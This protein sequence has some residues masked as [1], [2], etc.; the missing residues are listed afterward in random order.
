MIKTIN[1]EGDSVAVILLPGLQYYTGQFVNVEKLTE[2]AHAK[3]IIV[4]VDCAHAVGN[5]PL[6]L[7]DWNVDFAAW[8]TY[9]VAKYPPF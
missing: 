1:E 8:C 7:H 4:G 6:R 5:V 2:A 3:G 9:K